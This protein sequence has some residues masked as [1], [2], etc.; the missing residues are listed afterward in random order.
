MLSALL[1]LLPSISTKQ[2]SS[3]FDFVALLVS[4][5]PDLQP[6]CVHRAS[7]ESETPSDFYLAYL[8]SLLHHEDGNDAAKRDKA[9]VRVSFMLA[10]RNF[11]QFHLL[12]H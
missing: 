3:E 10:L 6:W 9:L 5:Y 1:E 7:F 12:T 11:L 4:A 2:E 8:S